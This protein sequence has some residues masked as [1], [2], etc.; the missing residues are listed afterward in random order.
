MVRYRTETYSFVGLRIRASIS[1]V[2]ESSSLEEFK[3]KIKRWTLKNYPCKLCK[4]YVQ[5][6]VM[7]DQFVCLLVCLF[8]WLFQ[9]FCY[10]LTLINMI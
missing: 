9:I 7:H 5:R 6:G 2:E 4:T 1:E 10:K 3:A 8:D